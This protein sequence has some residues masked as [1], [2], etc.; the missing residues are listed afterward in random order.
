MRK[1]ALLSFLAAALLCF[2]VGANADEKPKLICP[3]SGKEASKEHSVAYKKA[4]VYFCCENCPK[5]FE[6]DTAKFATKA[7]EQLVVTKQ[8]KQRMCPLSGQK[9]NPAT[10][11]D[12][13]GVKVAFCCDKCKAKVEGTEGDAKIALVFSDDA[14][15]KAFV[16]AKAKKK[17]KRKA[18]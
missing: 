17:N 4:K 3:V 9:L 11:I 12:V 2:S 8:Y 15:K 6:S 14:F 7:N 13:D 5:A 16:L 10:A 1:S 18:D